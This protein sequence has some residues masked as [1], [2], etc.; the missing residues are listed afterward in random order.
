MSMGLG[1]SSDMSMGLGESSDMSVGLGGP[2]EF[3]QLL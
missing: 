2:L 3:F 1:E